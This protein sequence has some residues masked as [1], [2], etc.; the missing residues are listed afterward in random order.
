MQ[1]RHWNASQAAGKALGPSA[2]NYAAVLLRCAGQEA[3]D[4]HEGNKWDVEGI[5][6][7][8]KPR[9]LDWGSG[10]RSRGAAMPGAGLALGMRRHRSLIAKQQSIH[11]TH[12]GCRACATQNCS[13][14][15]ASAA[16]LFPP[17]SKSAPGSPEA[18]MSRQ[19]ASTAGWLATTPTVRPLSRAKP[20]D[21]WAGTAWLCTATGWPCTAT[22]WSMRCAHPFTSQGYDRHRWRAMRDATATCDDVLGVVLADLKHLSVVHHLLDH[23]QHVVCLQGADEGSRERASSEPGKSTRPDSIATALIRA[24]RMRA[25]G[26]THSHHTARCTADGHRRWRQRQARRCAH[27][28]VCRPDLEFVCGHHIVQEGAGAVGRVDAGD[29]Q[30][31]VRA[32]AIRWPC[33]AGTA[34]RGACSPPLLAGRHARRCCLPVA[35]MAKQEAGWRQ[36]LRCSGRDTRGGL[37]VCADPAPHPRQRVTIGQRQE[38]EQLAHAGKRVQLVVKRAVRHACTTGARRRTC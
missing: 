26:A 32:E 2:P 33:G 14:L 35:P 17:P 25:L 31:Q 7:P 27:G 15:A 38:A 24:S 4:V 20:A 10:R 13:L 21:G 36:A 30:V 28:M 22:G 16:G 11:T 34:V 19:P 5:T 12:K 29:L 3:R 37:T 1:G 18:S 6:E 23:P 8:H 9:A